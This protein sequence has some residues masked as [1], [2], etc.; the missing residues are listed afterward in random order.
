MAQ[1]EGAEVRFAM[2]GPDCD[3]D[4]LIS[5]AAARNAEDSERASSAGE[6]R[7]LIGEFLEETGTQT[8]SMTN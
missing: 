3:H 5:F 2:N 8:E 4:R 6:S 1:S 7:Q